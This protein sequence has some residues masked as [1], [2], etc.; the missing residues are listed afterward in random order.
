[1]PNPKRPVE[2][3]RNGVRFAISVPVEYEKTYSIAKEEIV[4][5][6]LHGILVEV[7]YNL[8]P[9]RIFHKA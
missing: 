4:K 7:E 1:M 3:S 8:K 6:L 2:G 5:K 9:T